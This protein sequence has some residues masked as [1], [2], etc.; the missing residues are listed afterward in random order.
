MSDSFTERLSEYLDDE[1]EPAKRRAV[2][3]HLARCTDCRRVVE[4]LRQVIARAG[5]L[6]PRS[7]EADLWSGIEARIQAP[8]ASPVRRP[9]SVAFTLPQ[10]VA[11]SLALMV[12]SGG[13]VWVAQH[14]GRATSLPSVSAT[15]DA[16]ELDRSAPSALSDP[17]YDKTVAD[18]EHALQSR[19]SALDPQTAAGIE[20]DLQAIDRAIAQSR[21]GVEEDPANAYLREHLAATRQQKLALLRHAIAMAD[22]KGS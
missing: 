4:D 14:G 11:A 13:A 20:Q 21:R 5:S 18:L 9:W 6:Q 7:P 10:Y 1:M 19:R 2:E 3:A 17:A 16:G 15:R 12:V 22:K 8:V